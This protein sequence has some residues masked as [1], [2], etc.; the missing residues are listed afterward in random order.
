MKLDQI[1]SMLTKISPWPWYSD[2]AS[3]ICSKEGF[4]VIWSDHVKDDQGGHN[5]E[6]IAKS[7]ELVDQLVKMV[8]VAKKA[9]ELASDN[10]CY[11]NGYDPSTAD[12]ALATLERLENE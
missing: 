9:L 8:E 10:D 7:P 6:F 11:C 3:H 12:E 5:S 1:K 4:C 2:R